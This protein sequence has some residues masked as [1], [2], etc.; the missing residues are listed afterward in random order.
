MMEHPSITAGNHMVRFDQRHLR[1][2]KRQQALFLDPSEQTVTL[3]AGAL[4]GGPR[5]LVSCHLPPASFRVFAVLLLAAPDIASHPMLHASLSCP[6]VCLEAMLA[7]GS[8]LVAEFQAMVTEWRKRFR[9]LS[10]A[11]FE[12]QLQP[13]RYAVKKLNQA[14]RQKPFDWRVENKYGQG[15]VLVGVTLA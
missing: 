2:L 15:Y 5:S 1:L 8:L 6:D 9:A 3:V 14:L 12:N 7:S 13:V 4:N 10:E 11:E